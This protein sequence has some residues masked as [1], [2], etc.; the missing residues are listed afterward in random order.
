[1][2]P[3]NLCTLSFP[4][5]ILYLNFLVGSTNNPNIKFSIKTFTKI[6]AQTNLIVEMTFIID[7][8]RIYKIR[9]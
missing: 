7:K 4:I 2:L 5:G 1:M 6:R 9:T 3:Y 8:L